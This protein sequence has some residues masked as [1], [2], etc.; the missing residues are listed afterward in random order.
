MTWHG[1]GSPY[2]YSSMLIVSFTSKSRELYRLSGKVLDL[3]DNAAGILSRILAEA[4][5]ALP[6]NEDQF[7]MVQHTGRDTPFAALQ[8]LKNCLELLFIDILRN[9]KTTLDIEPSRRMPDIVG[10]IVRYLQEKHAE[11]FSLKE[12]S[13]AFHYHPNYLCRVFKRATGESIVECLN[14]LRIERAQL[15]INEKKLSLREISDACGFDTMQYFTNRFKKTV[16]LT[17]AQFRNSVIHSN[18]IDHAPLF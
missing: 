15:L 8:C 17:P 3:P 11:P 1:G 4:N 2:G 6:Y 10:K 5:S 9:K 12:M 16:G 18:I 14:R 7:N 13:I